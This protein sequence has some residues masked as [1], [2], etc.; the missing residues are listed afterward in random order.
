[1]GTCRY[2]ER[3]PVKFGHHTSWTQTC[4]PGGD[5]QGSIGPGE[6]LAED[7]DG[8]SVRV[9]GAL[10]VASEHAVVHE[11]EVDHSVRRRCRSSKVLQIIQVAALDL[12][13]ECRKHGSSVIGPSKPDDGMACV[14]KLGNNCGANVARGS[15]YEDAHECCSFGGFLRDWS[16]PG[17][18]Q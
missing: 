15:G 6:D 1:M 9:R 2:L 16:R 14:E 8:A 18:S 3:V 17:R 5:D 7:L 13:A 12:S 10:H 11:C 4:E